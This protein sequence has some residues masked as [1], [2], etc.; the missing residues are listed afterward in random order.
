MF[1]H[2]S[3]NNY[4]TKIK[5]LKVLTKKDPI[6]IQFNSTPMTFTMEQIVVK[7]FEYIAR[8]LKMVIGEVLF[9]KIKLHVKL[10]VE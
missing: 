6:E 4:Y 1:S 9:S 8:V 3:S 7:Y 2:L 5:L 10:L